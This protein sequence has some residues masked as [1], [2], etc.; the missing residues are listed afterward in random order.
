MSK[1]DL[2]DL[3]TFVRVVERG[4]FA[5]VGRELSLPTSTVSR[6]IVRLEAQA[7]VRLL[8][9]TTRASQPTAEGRALYDEVAPA[10]ATLRAAGRAI[11]PSADAPTGRL[12]VSAPTDLA[13]GFLAPV[14]AEFAAK[15]P[16]LD[17]ELALTNAHSDLVAEGFDVALRATA[18]LK[19]SSL[20]AR[21]LGVMEHRLYAAP[22]YIAQHGTPRSANELSRHSLV[23]FRARQR[24]R[25]WTLLG[26][27]SSTS[28]NVS[29]RLSGDDFSFVRAMVLAGAG[30]AL[31]PMA[32]ASGD[33]DAGRLVRVLPALHAKGA[34]LYL[35]Y[36]SAK[37]VPARVRAFCEFVLSAFARASAARA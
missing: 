15:F 16:A 18:L 10:L 30:I 37:N 13:A 6:A 9:R 32:N 20:V 8:Q 26:A 2:N 17:V 25:T 19:E 21:K 4:S 24:E 28:V 3:S 31:M 12:R 34:T 23:L 1:F 33:V 14:L 11:E 29:G 36:P 35:V 27:T 5:A 7:R 22:S